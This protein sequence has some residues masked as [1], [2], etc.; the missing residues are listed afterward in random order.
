VSPTEAGI[1][2]RAQQRRGRERD[3]TRAAILAAA[4]DLGRTEGWDAVTMRALADRLE[5][6]ANFAYRYFTGR[7]DI[8]LGVVR[9]GFAQLRDAM[10]DAAGA[11]PEAAGRARQRKPTE[12]AAVR[13]ASHAYLDFALT[14]PELY[15]LMYG[16]GGARVPATDAWSEGQAVR[17][18]LIDLL[19]AGGDPEPERH[20]LQLWAT[21]HGLIA[22][23]TAGRVI[24]DPAAL[25]GIIDDAIS[26]V[27]TRATASV[28]VKNAKEPSR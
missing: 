1:P 15:Q 2:S 14:E 13:R 28:P 7:D 10:S 11:D 17:D 16:V 8:L 6:S 20:V 3:A 22:L 18:V 27:L 26:D 19:R 5:Y 9:N 21:T 25:H 23:A 12:W 24:E 4:R